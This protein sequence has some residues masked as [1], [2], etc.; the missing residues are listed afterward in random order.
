MKRWLPAIAGIVVGFTVASCGGKV[1]VD[2]SSGDGPGGPS[3]DSYCEARDAACGINAA[4]CQAQEACAKA[5]L[6]DE[7]EVTLPTCLKQTCKGDTCLNAVSQEF[8]PTDKGAQFLAA[9]EAYLAACPTGNEDNAIIGSVFADDAIDD[10]LP[11][12]DAPGCAEIGACFQQVEEAT[13]AHC[14]DWL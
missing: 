12:L 5:L 11:C 8:P 2:A 1:V 6:R 3:W 7:I 14:R 9:H 4:T 10:F 13:V